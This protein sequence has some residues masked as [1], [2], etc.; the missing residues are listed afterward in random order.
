MVFI[1][2]FVSGILLLTCYK[3]YDIFFI[4]MSPNQ[5]GF[6]FLLKILL[7]SRNSLSAGALYPAIHLGLRHFLRP[8]KRLGKKALINLKMTELKFNLFL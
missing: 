6:A 3:N 1:R 4:I 5:L 2:R 7:I 8:F